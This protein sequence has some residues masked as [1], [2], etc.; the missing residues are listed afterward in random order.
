VTI[1]VAFPLGFAFP[2]GIRLAR[3]SHP[4]ETP[5]F[6]GLNGIGSVMA[7]SLAVL[8]ALGAGLTALMLA[9]AML[10][11]ALVPVVWVMRKSA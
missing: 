9:G 10:Y 1:A 3:A 6:W 8:V 7:S 11:L 5:W 4:D 2:A